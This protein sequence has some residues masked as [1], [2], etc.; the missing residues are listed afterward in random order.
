MAIPISIRLP[1]DLRPRLDDLA[2]AERRSLANLIVVLLEEA[3]SAREK[4]KK[5][6]AAK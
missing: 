3:L 1:D 6:R 2:E 5:R 4:P